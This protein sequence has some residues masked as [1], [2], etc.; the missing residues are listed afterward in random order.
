MSRGTFWCIVITTERGA[1]L[2][3]AVKLA[4]NFKNFEFFYRKEFFLPWKTLLSRLSIKK[5]KK[6]FWDFFESNRPSVFSSLR[7]D[8]YSMIL[9]LNNRKILS[10]YLRGHFRK[11]GWAEHFL[12]GRKSEKTAKKG[13]LEPMG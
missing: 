3:F 4:K 2:M 7:S 13:H 5:S 9:V 10:G 11:I 6:N 1:A 8:I 12:L